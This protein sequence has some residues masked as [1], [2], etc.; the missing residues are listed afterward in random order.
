MLSAHPH[1]MPVFKRLDFRPVRGRGCRLWD[2]EGREFLDLYGGHA[3]AQTGHAH[4]RVVAAIEKEAGGLLFYSNALPLDARDRLFTRLASMAPAGLDRVFLV[5]SG[6]EA[7]D[8]ALA[9]A[10]RATGRSGVVVC[11]GGFHGR[12]LATLAASGI[13]KY[14]ALAGSCE[15]GRELAA[16]TSVVPFDDAEALEKALDDQVAAFLVEPVQGLGG[17]RAASAGF[18]AAAREICSERGIALLF[19]EVQC[20][21]GR[22]GA[23]CAA[24]GYGVVPDALTLAKGLASGLPI[25]ALLASARLSE[26]IF[27]GDMGSTFGGGPIPC[28]AAVA[29]LDILEDEGLPAR[30]LTLAQRLRTAL[31]GVEGV[32]G[33][34]GRG[35]LLGIELDRPASEVQGALFD[36]RVLTGSSIDPH[37]LRL[38]PPLVLE[39]RELDHFVDLLCKVLGPSTPAEE[40]P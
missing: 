31:Q 33:V 14:R 38:L 17:A 40:S 30:A 23:F 3:V 27:V 37:V 22:T 19:D 5:N 13:A 7:N 28:A 4:P 24:Q 32:R 25:G 16:W 18:L 29:T 20:G 26:G 12:S 35:L 9:L 36:E 8:Q 15:A 11:E 10:R 2:A 6:A 39:E 34:R 1:E 21:V